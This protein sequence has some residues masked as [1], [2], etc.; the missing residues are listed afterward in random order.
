M[1]GTI[2]KM[3]TER[4][5]GGLD[6]AFSERGGDL[7]PNLPARFDQRTGIDCPT[8]EGDQR[9][10]ADEP[11]R[12]HLLGPQTI[13]CSDDELRTRK[14]RL[15]QFAELITVSGVHRHHHVIWSANVNRS[16]KSRFMSAR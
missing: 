6:L 8:V 3:V 5:G 11:G 4:R 1:A 10:C 14:M 7:V 16:P 12:L 9:F 15:Q 13:M 2:L